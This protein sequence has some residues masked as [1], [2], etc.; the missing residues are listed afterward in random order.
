MLQFAKLSHICNQNWKHFFSFLIKNYLKIIKPKGRVLETALRW[1]GLCGLAV[2]ERVPQ[3]NFLLIT[4]NGLLKITI[5]LKF[6]N[7]HKTLP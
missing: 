5:A 1:Q 2:A 3:S 4:A 6:V 7:S